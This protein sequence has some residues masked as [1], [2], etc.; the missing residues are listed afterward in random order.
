MFVAT[1][2]AILLGLEAHPVRVELDSTP[3]IRQFQ[4]VGLPDG[5]VRESRERVSA[6][7]VNAGFAFPRGRIVCNLAPADLRK[8]GTSFDAAIA[9]GLLAL[10]G[11]VSPS[12][13]ED[14]MIVGELSL[15]G[16]LRPVRGMLSIALAAR[17]AGAK[18]LVLPAQNEQEARVVEHLNLY[19][20]QTLG[21]IH[22]WL[23]GKAE[24]PLTEQ[25]P[26]Q[27]FLAAQEC[28]QD[29]EETDLRDVK[30]QEQIKRVMEIAAAGQHH[31]LM[32]GPPGS[33]KTMLSQRFAGILPPLSLDEAVDLTRVHSIGGLV[34][35]Q[36]P[37]LRRRPHR[38]PH[39]TISRPGLVGGGSIPQP[40][41]ISFAHHGVLF[42]DELPE[43]PRAVLELLRQ[44]ME[45]RRLTIS[46]AAMSLSFP[47]NFLFVAA[48]NPCP[49]GYLGDP[50]RACRC[51]PQEVHR[52]RARVSGPL[53][54]RV[55]L[56]VDVPAAPFEQLRGRGDGESSATVRARVVRARQR[57]HERLG[58]ALPRVN[59]QM[60]P[61]EI[62]RDVQLGEAGWHLL[63]RATERLA[64]ST[65]AH[66]RVLKVA[67]TIAD[68]A[69]A[70]LVG[71]Q[72][73]SEAIQYQRIALDQGS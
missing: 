19:P 32:L 29:G 73:L 30:G 54:D 72:H 62:D 55:D 59:G 43:F 51:S 35:P 16:I 68:L 11:F 24:L 17:T 53:L 23:N 20:A 47:C 50:R 63:Q 60:S 37:L 1:R 71:L 3:G 45:E 33:G 9:V 31:L 48:M 18:G 7:L 27:A 25:D 52:Y 41:E 49:C 61:A 36:Q 15:E 69:E 44:P 38:A 64:L 26:R 67:R 12:A 40:G 21:Q 8:G 14:L 65:R 6:A 58:G 34:D 4:I 10:S 22:K 56:R 70:D 28:S 57:Q 2:S 42:L 39:H 66:M 5:A 46:R 13:L